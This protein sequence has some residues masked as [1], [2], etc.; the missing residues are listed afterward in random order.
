MFVERQT[1]AVLKQAEELITSGFKEIVLTGVHVGDFGKDK[2]GKSALPALLSELC[3]LNAGVRWRL[4]SLDPDDLDESLIETVE[5]NP[6][7]CRHFHI[8]R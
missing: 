7:I 3:D 2:L 5:K 4:S 6:Q 8:L 1:K